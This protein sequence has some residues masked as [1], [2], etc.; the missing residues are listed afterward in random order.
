MKLFLSSIALTASVGVWM[1]VVASSQLALLD[2]ARTVET[3]SGA[4]S[5]PINRTLKRDRLD[6]SAV[7]PEKITGEKSGD[8][9]SVGGFDRI[10]KFKIAGLKVSP[11]LVL[12]H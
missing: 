4:L 5:N 9:C 10:C 2:Q 1:I 3:V 7:T 6:L 12:T 11:P 8:F